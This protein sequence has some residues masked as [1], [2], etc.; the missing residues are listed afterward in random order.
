MN[1]LA[2]SSVYMQPIVIAA[3][4]AAPFIYLGSIALGRWLKKSQRVE[5]GVLYQFLCLAFAAYVPLKVLHHA[6]NPE[7]LVTVRAWS[8]RDNAINHFGSAVILLGVVFVLALLRRFYWQNW[9][10]HRHHMEAP[11]FLQQIFSFVAFTVSCVLVARW[12]Y[13][14][15][16][17]AFLTGSGILAVVIGFAMQET[18]A[19]IISGVALQIGKPFKVGDWLIIDGVNTSLRAEVVELN[20]RST[21]LRTTDDIYLDIPNK[22][23]TS[24]TV[25]NLSFP[26]RTHSNRIK[27]GFMYD[28]PPNVVR[29]IV[30]KATEAA[31]GVVPHPPVKVFLKDYAE[32]AIVYEIKYSLDDESRFNDIENE[33][34]TNLWY[35]ARRAGIPMP[36]P[37]RM[38]HLRRDKP[39]PTELPERAKELLKR[40]EML[41]PLS[42]AQQAE[43]VSHVSSQRFGRGEFIIH[44]G[45]NGASMFVILEGQADVVVH[46]NEQELHVATLREGD[47]FG[48]MCLL[49]GEPRTADVIARTD[50]E[51]WELR[52]SVL[53]PILQENVGLANRLSVLLAKRKLETEGII[54]ASTPPA[55]AELKKQEYARTFMQKISALFEL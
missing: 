55:F 5:L 46:S 48:E 24:S 16:V 17:D 25:T 10:R 52:R 33:I 34:R 15:Q 14:A 20:W 37:M 40:N 7:G 9:F 32:T 27:V 2:F 39:L 13:G 49:T 21:R 12:G 54:A 22:T 51:V 19:N 50:C 4:V 43:L 1:A 18:L 53:Q 8:W 23:V 44:Q 3:L 6:E 41:A 26:T 30:R 38:V 28:T 35:E 42:Q 31:D 45:A 36:N 11:K 29:D 47:A